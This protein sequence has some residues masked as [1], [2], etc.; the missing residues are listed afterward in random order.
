MPLIETVTYPDLLT[1]AEAAQ[2][3]QYLRQLTRSTGKVRS[4]VGAAREDVNVS[5]TGGTRVEIKGVGSIRLIPELTHN[6]AFRQKALLEI[7][8]ILHE[9]VA[10]PDQ[11]RIGWHD[12]NVADFADGLPY[13]AGSHKLRL[14]AINLPSFKGLLSFFTQPGKTF[15]SE[16][17]DRLKVI[18]CLERPN[19][20]HSEA[21]ARP[22]TTDLD[23]IRRTLGAGDRRCPGAGVGTGC[24]RHYGYRSNRGTL[25]HGV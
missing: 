18:A 12:L 1:P 23:M 19:L 8:K 4:G 17:R 5:I 3:A 25:P 2:A 13:Q 11:W 22:S 24:R 21:N 6:E 20:I 10:H 7:R 9:R 14:T 15:A 16:L